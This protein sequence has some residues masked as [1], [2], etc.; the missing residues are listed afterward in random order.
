MNLLDMHMHFGTDNV[1]VVSLLLL[2]WQS[3]RRLLTR[4]L[5]FLLY[6]SVYLSV[7][8]LFYAS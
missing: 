2:F 6:V 3:G 8:L 7:S 1:Y 4:I 5:I